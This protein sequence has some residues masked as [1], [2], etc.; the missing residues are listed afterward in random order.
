MGQTPNS[1]VPK[2]DHPC[3]NE[4]NLYVSLTPLVLLGVM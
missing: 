1:E 4:I 2:R 3:I